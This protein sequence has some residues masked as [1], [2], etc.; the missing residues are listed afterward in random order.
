MKNGRQGGRTIVEIISVIALVAVFS[1]FALPP[2]QGMLNRATLRSERQALLQDIRTLR[3]AS[4]ES[5]RPAYLCALDSEGGCL[6]SRRWRHGWMGFVDRDRDARYEPGIDRLV[7]L[8]T[9][10]AENSRV[11]IFMHSR[12]LDIKFDGRGVLRR[13]GHL[14]ICDPTDSNP[15]LMKLIRMNTFGRL[16]VETESQRCE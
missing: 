10:Q 2:V 3:H 12:W 16:A 9:G 11:A 13:S 14:R 8:H 5:R 15:R 4:I 6:R 7:L 1:V